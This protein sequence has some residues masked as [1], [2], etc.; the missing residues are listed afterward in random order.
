M[1]GLVHRPEQPVEVALEV[2]RRDPDVLNAA[3]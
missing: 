2:P 1:A 3:A